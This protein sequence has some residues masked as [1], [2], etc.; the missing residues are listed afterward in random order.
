MTCLLLGPGHSSDK[1]KV[2]GDFG[3][4]YAKIRHTNN[5][6]HNHENSNKY[7]RQHYN[8]TIVN[9]A[10]DEIIVQENNKVSAWTESQEVIDMSPPWPRSFIR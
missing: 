6:G 9:S 8:N 5:R 1:Y 2:Q 3:S 7:T 10:V 4:K